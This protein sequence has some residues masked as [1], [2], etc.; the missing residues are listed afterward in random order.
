MLCAEVLSLLEIPQGGCVVDAT[1]G[2]GGHAT[3]FLEQLG[4]D[5]LLIGLDAD[6]RNIELARERLG[7]TERVRLYH[8]NFENIEEVL[9]QVGRP[10]VDRVLADLGFSSNQLADPSRGLSFNLEGPLDMR[11]DLRT[12]TTAA[13]LVNRLAQKD[14]A[15]LI[16]N[17]AQE[18]ASR[19][20]AKAIH[21]ARRDRRITTT[22]QLRDIVCKAFKISPADH[23]NRIHPATRTFMALRIAVNREL[24]VLRQFVEVLPKILAPNGRA[25]VISFHS[26]EDGICKRAFRQ[27][28]KDGLVDII[29]KKPV[30]P[31]QEERRANPRSR[32]AKLRVI[33]RTSTD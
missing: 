24:E 16:Y 14:L 17:N 29:T 3:L 2:L 4:P 12:K 25:G 7:Q 28:K 19:R 8:G 1:V 33:R 26:L 9:N 15:D 20:I 31:S 6:A 18:R 10:K 5:G 11:I 21:Q 32:S 23:R 13:D 22:T 27:M 30:T